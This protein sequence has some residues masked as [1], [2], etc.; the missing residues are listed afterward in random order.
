MDNNEDKKIS[1]KNLGTEKLF[2]LLIVGVFLLFLSSKFISTNPKQDNNNTNKPQVTQ[3]VKNENQDTYV[4]LLEEKL[5]KILLKVEGVG[6]VEVMITLKSSKE[7]I[8]N[9]D[10][11]YSINETTEEDGEGGQR[12]S[13]ESNYDE[14][15]VL[16]N[17]TDGTTKPFVVKE[18][19]PEISG[20]LIIAEGGDIPETKINLTNVAEVLFNVPAHK[21]KV[22]KMINN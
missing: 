4:D 9:K 17:E 14:K 19:E 2:T 11:P 1:L 6:K 10:Q 5:E 20:I 21:I 3:I 15:T 18:N 12:N 13:N 22:M 7:L 16:S 8:L